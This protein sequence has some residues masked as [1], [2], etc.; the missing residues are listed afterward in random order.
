MA[1]IF[2]PFDY[3]KP[4]PGVPKDASP[5]SG[6]RVF[7]EVLK[8]KLWAI[9][10]LNLLYTLFNLIGLVMVFFGLQ[11]LFPYV[12]YDTPE[13]DIFL[14][15]FTGAV[16]LCIPI[17]SFGPAQAGMTYVL[18]NYSREEHAFT[19]Y[20][21]KK[22]ALNNLRQSLLLCVIDFIT[23]LL[24]C[25]AIN[26]YSQ[27]ISVYSWAYLAVGMI[28]AVFIF[29][30]MTHLF[31][32]PMLVTFH[33]TIKQLYKNAL[34]FSALRF[35]PNL[36]ILLI[37]VVIILLSFVFP[38]LGFLLFLLII[39]SLT[40]FINTSYACRILAKYMTPAADDSTISE[41]AEDSESL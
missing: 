6:I 21:F 7:F 15:L 24:L 35:L 31:I 1:G 30:L 29:F 14:R 13:A 28:F 27:L 20:D 37:D 2:N 17:V 22:H 36:G 10:K 18:R 16:F 25:F 32:Y 34:I 19:W 8:R 38:V 40:G 39:P 23:F 41:S 5:K 4:G 12:I 26:F 11:L 3:S 33:L 9:I